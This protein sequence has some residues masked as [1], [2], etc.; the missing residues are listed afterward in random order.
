MTISDLLLRSCAW[1]FKCDKNWN[2]LAP[3][4]F[5]NVRH[6]NACDSPVHCKRSPDPTFQWMT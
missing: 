1:G 2:D 6:C 3:T 4:S 5:K